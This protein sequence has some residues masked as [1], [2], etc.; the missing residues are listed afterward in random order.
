MGIN[1]KDDSFKTKEWL[2]ELGNPYDIIIIDKD[3]NIGLNWGVYGLPETFIVNKENI[4]T[5]KQVGP[6]TNKNIDEFYENIL[7]N[8]K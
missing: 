2:K 3:G 5:Y 1:Y 6:I 7:N 4:I 8:L